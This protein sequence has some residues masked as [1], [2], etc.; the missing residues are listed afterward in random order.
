MEL[1]IFM[2]E[3]FLR[4]KRQKKKVV[5]YHAQI[6]PGSARKQVGISSISEMMVNKKKT[7]KV[8]Q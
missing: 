1:A 4:K 2:S 6:D 3:I 5:H 8:K 7:N